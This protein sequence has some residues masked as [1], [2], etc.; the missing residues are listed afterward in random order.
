M[1]K[2]DV[3][4]DVNWSKKRLREFKETRIVQL[5]A[6]SNIVAQP[7][8]DRDRATYESMKMEYESDI[9]TI[10]VLLK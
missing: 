10:D 5:K 8:I 2:L 6:I 7:L 4:L 1:S 9:K 3:K